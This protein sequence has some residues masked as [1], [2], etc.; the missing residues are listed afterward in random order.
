MAVL[1]SQG[2]PVSGSN[3]GATAAPGANKFGRVEPTTV[4][5]NATGLKAGKR[6][7]LD[8]TEDA[9]ANSAPPPKG[10]YTLKVFLAK[11]GMKMGLIDLKD[12]DSVFYE[13][14]LETKVKHD[15]P[16]YDNFT[17]FSRVSTKIGR[18]KNISTMA[19]LINKMGYKLPDEATPLQIA[20]LLKAAIAKEPVLYNNMLDWSG[21]SQNDNK[22]ICTS[23]DDF[24]EDEEGNPVHEFTITNKD[25]GREK[26]QAKLKIRVWGSKKANPVATTAGKANGKAVVEDTGE[27]EEAIQPVSAKAKAA[28]PAAAPK[29]LATG[30]PK[31]KAQPAPEPD[32]EEETEEVE[33]VAANEEEE[34][35]LD[36]D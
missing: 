29:G 33:E 20:K 24:P 35:A 13:A 25:G 14:E 28:T 22:V 12:E 32:I 26:I 27:A 15:N 16:E 7:K 1:N 10:E 23:M 31:P 5:L 30:K 6:S 11:D 9:W 21:W 2:K 18:G 17:V 19:G 3:T 34:L 36:E 8:P 4:D